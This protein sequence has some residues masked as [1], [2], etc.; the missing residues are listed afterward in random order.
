MSQDLVCELQ[1]EKHGQKKV[2]EKKL[3]ESE[4]KGE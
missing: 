1:D 2:N 3:M 4:E